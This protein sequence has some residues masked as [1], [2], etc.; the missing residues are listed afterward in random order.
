MHEGEGAASDDRF[1]TRLLTLPECLR[2]ILTAPSAICRPPMGAK[3]L[4]CFGKRVKIAA[5]GGLADEKGARQLFDRR[6]LMLS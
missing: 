2:Q 5:H 1:G 3:Q 4:A 6:F